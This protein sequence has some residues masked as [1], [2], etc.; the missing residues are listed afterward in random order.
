MQGVLFSHQA[1]SH[2][3]ADA[4]NNPALMAV[5]CVGDRHLG[6]IPRVVGGYQY[7][8]VVI[9]KFTKWSEATHMVTINEQ[10]AIKFIK[11]IICKFGLPNEIITDNASQFTSR[12]SKNTTKT[13][14]SKSATHPLGIQKVMDKSREPMLKSSGVSRHAPMNA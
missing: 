4:A 7:L 12:V 6:T 11:A 5:H 2:T 1:D 8:Y 13:L 10:S 14:A 9:D 3:D